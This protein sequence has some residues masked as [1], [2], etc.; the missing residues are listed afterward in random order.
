MGTL[1]GSIG[2]A[3][4][5][6]AYH[7][8]WLVMT[9]HP[10]DLAYKSGG[11]PELSGIIPTSASKRIRGCDSMSN[12]A[13]TERNSHQEQSSESAR[14]SSRGATLAALDSMSGR[15]TPPCSGVDDYVLT[16]ASHVSRLVLESVRQEGLAC[17]RLLRPHKR[18]NVEGPRSC[19]H[20]Q[21]KT[22]LLPVRI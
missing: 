9:A 5:G 8:V 1:L 16:S 11:D 18:R 22:L 15:G 6:K 2:A 4:E 12:R 17:T 14:D 21:H 7:H 3:C 20:M 13:G 19:F 10:I